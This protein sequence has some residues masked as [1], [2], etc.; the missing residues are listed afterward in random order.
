MILNKLVIGG[1]QIGLKYGI[2]NTVGRPDNH[3]IDKMLTLAHKSGVLFID[4]AQNYGNSEKVIGNISKFK[5]NI[6]TK[7]SLTKE[8]LSSLNI[9][10]LISKKFK[11]SI[12]NLKTDN[13]YSIMLHDT[14][15]LET[16]S[17]NE[18]WDCLSELKNNN[19]VKKIGF[20]IYRPQELD[21]VFRKFK[22]DIIQTPYNLLDQ[23]IKL[24]GWLDIL[25]KENVE[26][27]ARSIFLQ[28]LLLMDSKDINEKFGQWSKEFKKLFNWF[29][30]K[31][32]SKLEGCLYFAFSEPKIDKFVIGTNSEMELAQI[33]NV[34][35]NSKN[36]VFD[37][38][39]NIDDQNLLEPMNW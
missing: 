37:Y 20:S 25:K 21:L 12:N 28:G 27:H 34:L 35:K 29:N 33:I 24:S 13:V 11:T 16:S 19:L 14:S 9:K 31:G 23:R 10:S 18:I 26:V 22:P 7:L 6:N 36:E 30:F 32:F 38:S 39:S 8:E 1:A 15:Y 4:T 17:A 5:W 2:S 3:E